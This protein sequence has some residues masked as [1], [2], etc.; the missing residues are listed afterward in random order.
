MPFSRAMDVTLRK[1][2]TSFLLPLDMVISAAPR[3]KV[4]FQSN[5]I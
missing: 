3:L 4:A 2:K 1:T 5:A